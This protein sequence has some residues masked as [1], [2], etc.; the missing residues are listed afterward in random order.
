MG[1]VNVTPDSFSDG[2]TFSDESTGAIDHDAAIGHAQNLVASGADLIDVGGESTRPGAAPIDTAEELERV[3]PVVA[4]LA[5]D[6]IPVSIDT[7]KPEVAR[8]AVEVGAEVINDVTGLRDPQMIG[9]AVDTGAGVVIM[10]MQGVPQTMH[11]H[12]G[13]NHHLGS[14]HPA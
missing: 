4:S 8:A 13:S 7:S 1:I 10:H 11:H 3:L 6:G 5:R 9:V 2:G 14:G 12:L